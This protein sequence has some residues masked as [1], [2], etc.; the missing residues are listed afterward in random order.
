MKKVLKIFFIIIVVIIA[1]PII[2]VIS[3]TS[4]IHYRNVYYYKNATP[5]GEIEKKYTALGELKVSYKEFKCENQDYKKY[6][7]FYPSILEKEN[8]TYPLVIMVNGTGITASKYKEVL[9]HL[10]SWGFIVVGNEDANSRSGYSSSLSLDFM[11]EQNKNPES[12]FYNKID[13]ENIGIAG[14]SQGGVGA[15][16]AVTKQKNGNMYKAIWTASTTSNY[17]KQDSVFGTSWGYDTSEINIPYFMVAG[18]GNADAGTAENINLTEGQ[19]ICP[20]Y[21]MNYNYS[22]I[23]NSNDKV[24]ARLKN[25]DHGDMLRYADGYMTAWFI[26]YLQQNSEL[27]HVFYGENSELSNNT[28]WQD[29]KANKMEG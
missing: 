21:D 11:I 25:K 9:K 14:H 19:G 3:C 29:V 26:Y 4:I 17:W 28:N 7:I 15:I 12:M 6:E 24:M 8:K 22:R 18:T 27:K 20:L 10:S 16:N 1:L 23:S 2:G 13:L 5:Y